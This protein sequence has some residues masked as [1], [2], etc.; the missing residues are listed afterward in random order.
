M[1]TANDISLSRTVRLMITPGQDTSDASVN[2]FAALVT[3]PG[4]GAYYEFILH[5]SGPPEARTGFVESIY[6]MDRAVQGTLAPRISKAL[7][8]SDASPIAILKASIPGMK[9]HLT[10]TLNRV[11]WQL[12]PTY[13]ISMETIDMSNFL[14]AQQ[15][16]F[17]ASHRLHNPDYDEDV[18]RAVFGKCCNP[19]GHGHNYRLEVEVKVSGEE[20]Q[21]GYGFSIMDLDKVVH[22]HVIEDYDHTYLNLDVDEFSDC[23][24]TV[25]NITLMCHKRLENP[26]QQHGVSLHRVRLWETEKTCCSYPVDS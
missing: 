24:P 22:E 26:L 21:P 25:E 20:G 14:L 8:T 3:T 19:N 12:S 2:S 15:Y 18:N 7:L 1:T 23:N 9:D 16:Q 10:S 13:R 6:E 4:L 17:A 5:C 11:D